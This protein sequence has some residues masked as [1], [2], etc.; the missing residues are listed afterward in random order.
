MEKD[1]ARKAIIV[2]VLAL[3]GAV[4][5]V[6][7]ADRAPGVESCLACTRAADLAACHLKAVE[8][9]EGHS[10]DAAITI[11]ERVHAQQPGNAEVAA[12]L[13]KMYQQGRRD[14]VRAIALY[15]A[16][17][18]A[19]SGFPPALL[20]LGSIMQE[21][22]KDDIALRYFARGAKERPDLPLFKVRQA[23]ALVRLGRGE[24]AQPILRQVVE[25]WPQSDEAETARR[26]MSRT[27]LARP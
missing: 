4:G 17:L 3:A 21:Q 1:A 24:E 20:G 6:K 27:S 11:E 2:A 8:L 10:F 13:A 7:A 26:M 15:H 12:A 23:D 14:T 9:A 18:D 16:A 5:A 22:G 19:S 25:A